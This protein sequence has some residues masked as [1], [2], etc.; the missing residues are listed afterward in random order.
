MCGTQELSVLSQFFCKNSLFFMTHNVFWSYYNINAFLR[1]KLLT[2]LH[3][4]F[5][6]ITWTEFLIININQIPRGSFGA[7][8]IDFPPFWGETVPQKII[9]GILHKN[10][11][12]DVINLHMAKILKYYLVLEWWILEYIYFK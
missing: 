2:F 8:F 10:A 1:R 9:N 6:S 7:S 3:H 11:V 5:R 4:K 12:I